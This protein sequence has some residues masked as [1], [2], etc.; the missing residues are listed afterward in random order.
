MPEYRI[1]FARSAGREMERLSADVAARVLSRIEAL[2]QNPRPPGCR[3]VIGFEGLW[4]IRSG[5]Y[6]VIYQV[7]EDEHVVDVVAVR[8]RS[9]AYRLR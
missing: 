3:K 8:H 5:D 4:R 2:A 9:D 1:T 6:R 7:L